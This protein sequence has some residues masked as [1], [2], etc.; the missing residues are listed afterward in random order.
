MKKII[1]PLLTALLVSSCTV[2]PDYIQPTI[3]TPKDYKEA[4]TQ[5]KRAQP[6]D[7]QSR[8]AWWDVFN[9]KQLNTLQQQLTRSN[10]TI[11]SAIA[12]YQQASALIDEAK[13]AYFPVVSASAS[14][15]R[16]RDT[17]ADTGSQ[18]N[19]SSLSNNKELSNSNLIGLNASW[20]PDIW[21]A[22]RRQ[23]EEYSAGAQ[24]SD[25]LLAATTLSTQASLAQ[26]YF[27]LRALDT[28]QIL[29]D[30]IALSY[31][32]LLNYTQNQYKAG[33]VY[34]GDVLSAQAQ[35]DSARALAI[36]NG[37]LRAQYEH[38]IAVLVG[39]MPADFSLA[40]HPLFSIK[41]PDIPLSMPSTLLERRP[42][43]A[44][45]ERLMAEA[46][47]QISVAVSAYYPSL[48]LSA[49]GQ[50]PGEN[51]S[52]WFSLP[53]LYWSIGP[54]LAETLYDGGL[55]DA[56]VAASKAGYIAAVAN[57][58]QTVLSAFQ[59]VEGIHTAKHIYI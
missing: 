7:M 39:Q 54:Q 40:A 42:D 45:A 13:A 8:G 47:A 28:D 12:N 32:K 51:F 57:Y 18:T 24:A 14:L 37:I 29:L 41:A 31:E 38:A 25:A 43:I 1:S 55:R 22:V 46:N 21:G 33:I 10:Q 52:H 50:I 58:R 26:Y 5:W 48:T 11:M 15:D 34:Q 20:V 49:I 3:I 59:E 4:N 36:N 27:E 2:G 17:M 44:Q 53:N 9:D 35:W 19:T 23:V 16:T 56:T 30:K 6:R